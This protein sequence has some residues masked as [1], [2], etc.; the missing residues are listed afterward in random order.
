MRYLDGR[1]GQGAKGGSTTLSSERYKGTSVSVTAVKTRRGEQESPLL[2]FLTSTPGGSVLANLPC[3]EETP[4]PV[5]QE[6]G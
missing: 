3:K 2:S 6:V 5:Q 4:V 1:E